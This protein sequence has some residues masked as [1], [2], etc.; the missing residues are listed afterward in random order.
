MENL[1]FEGNS[2]DHDYRPTVNM[3]ADTGNCEFSGLSYPWD[4][5]SFYIPIIRWVE[6]YTSESN[7]SLVV[8]MK[9]DGFNTTSSAKLMKIFRIMEDYHL[10]QRGKAKI[11]W[12]YE[13]EDDDILELGEDFRKIL[14]LPME[15]FM[16]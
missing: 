12:Y 10:S 1:Y 16:K 13:E 2:I 7:K 6:Q 14:A 5:I 11:N 3:R 4:P 15:I 9:M 8:N